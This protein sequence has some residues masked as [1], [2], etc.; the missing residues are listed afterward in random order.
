MSTVQIDEMLT[1]GEILEI[2]DENLIVRTK[3]QELI[4]D[5]EFLV[6]QPTVKGTPLHAEHRDVKFAFYRTSG[7]YSFIA[8]ISAPFTHGSIRLCK[9]ERVSE[10]KKIQRRQYYRL[11]IVQDVFLYEMDDKGTVL[12]K[13]YKAR[14]RD[15][16]ERSMAVSSF[17]RFDADMPM[18]VE[19]QMPD[20]R[21]LSIQAK[22]LRCA[23]PLISTDPYDI[24]LVFTN[25]PHN[26]ASLR[27]YIFQQ[28][29]LLR[30][31]R[32]IKQP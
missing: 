13:R 14:T 28:Q 24:V 32:D 5:T 2:W 25:P 11:P 18:V 10:V 12:E 6:L 19:I 9:V 17:T 8:R 1:L 7:C 16:S 20:S 22:V 27:R 4:S 23:E 26:G 31:K 15:I 29:V 3:L 21:K 30:K